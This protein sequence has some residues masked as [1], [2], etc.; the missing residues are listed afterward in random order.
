M[1]ARRVIHYLTEGRPIRLA[2]MIDYYLI[3]GQLVPEVKTTLDEL[4]EKSPEELDA[5]REKVEAAILSQFQELGRPADDAIRA[6]AWAPKGMDA[7]LLSRVAGLERDEALQVLEAL[8][9]PTA[10][11]SFVKIRRPD[12]RAFLQDE[13]YALMRKHVLDH[14]PEAY[15]DDVYQDI[16]AYYTDRI[17]EAR[18]RV[19]RLG[20]RE[21]GLIQPDGRVVT[22]AAPGGPEDPA[23]LVDAKAQ[24]D[25]LLVE[26]TYYR[27]QADPVDGFETYCEYAEEAVTLN[28]DSLDMQLRDEIL[29]FVRRT[30][31]EGRTEVQGLKR[32]DVERHAAVHWVWR[33][34]Y[35]ANAPEAYRITQ[36]L[37]T[38]ET[39]F[40]KE[41]GSLTKA[42]LT[43]AEGWAAAFLGTDLA[44]TETRLEN[45]I[46][47]LGGLSPRSSF[48]QKQCDI[49]LAKACNTLGY[50]QRVQGRFQDACESYRRALPLWRLLEREADHAE[51]LNNLA[52]ALAEV[53][54][55]GRALRYCQDG[56]KL[57]EQLG[58]R[59]LL[60]LSY[61]TLGLIAIKSDQP[62]RG[63]VHSER[64]LAIFRDLELPRGMGLAYTVLA[65]AHRRSTD[66]QDVYFPAEKAE[67]LRFAEGFAALAV[68]IFRREVPE[69][70]R[71]V[72]AQNE[73]GCIYRN[74]ARL[75]PEHHEESDPSRE[76]LTE[77]GI[78]ALK[79]AAQL[80]ECAFPYRQVDA[81]VNLAWLYYY[82]GQPDRALEILNQAKA[83]LSPGY[84]ITKQRGLPQREDRVAFLWTQLGKAHLLQGEIALQRYEDQPSAK[85]EVRDEALWQNVAKHFTLALAYSELF[86]D[87]YRGMRGAKNTMYEALRGMNPNELRALYEGV[88]QT[89][90]EYHLEH[91]SGSNGQPARPRMRS[92][93][94]EYFGAPE[95]F[96][97]GSE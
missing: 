46:E 84:C 50:L 69:K 83:A 25:N 42:D 65:E 60:A 13:M 77:N 51:T 81:L 31:K 35:S 64:A 37:R 43:V 82:V 72:E 29:G 54:N 28:D 47:I 32:G 76:K 41:G 11:L 24:L 22:V 85:G 61:N 34:L 17:E 80:A 79:E 62:H 74:W 20:R 40:V 8:A 44:G 87:D 9:D 75:W 26:E 66:T 16:L 23:A 36:Y 59:Y 10:G 55:F 38:E 94:E 49:L 96:T 19:E 1:E 93:L 21:R 67:R 52:Y 88:A 97:E 56:L 86:A 3:T 58:H 90:Q 57:R 68:D 30:F 71:L 73:L 5:I 2:L 7:A 48:E 91:C 33:N 39:G 18:A 89:A 78:A 53:G 45:A 4:Q 27:L 70:L 6:L 15:A 14:L 92:F 63:R 95:E 12:R